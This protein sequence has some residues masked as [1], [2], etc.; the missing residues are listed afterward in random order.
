MKHLASNLPSPEELIDRYT[1]AN[2]RPLTDPSSYPHPL[3]SRKCHIPHSLLSPDI[4]LCDPDFLLTSDQLKLVSDSISELQSQHSATRVAVALYD[5]AEDF[6]QE[7]FSDYILENW[8]DFQGIALT[9]CYVNLEVDISSSPELNLMSPKV[10]RV[11]Y[12]ANSLPINEALVEVITKISNIMTERL[13]DS[14]EYGRS[15][16]YLGCLIISGL[17]GLILSVHISDN[18]AYRAEESHR[19]ACNE[20]LAKIEPMIKS[21]QVDKN[22]CPLTLTDMKDREFIL[23][24]SGVK[25][26]KRVA[27]QLNINMDADPVYLEQNTKWKGTKL[28]LTSLKSIFSDFVDE[29]TVQTFMKSVEKWEI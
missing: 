26:S 17:G 27:E 10:G 29:N 8:L 11:I 16:V 19:L 18:L 9:Y 4:L 14:V 3:E 25:Y 23:G 13:T 12:S 6:T 28:Y 24:K 2:H 7:E 1:L 20:V 22:F 5:H 21:K 15:F